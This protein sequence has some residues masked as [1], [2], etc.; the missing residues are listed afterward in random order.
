MLQSMESQLQRERQRRFEEEER[1]KR[2]QE[3]REEAER[4]KVGNGTFY[5]NHPRQRCSGEA[6]QTRRQGEAEGG[7]SDEGGEWQDFVWSET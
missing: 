2:E 6:R 3:R 7:G 4:E 5:K 1:G